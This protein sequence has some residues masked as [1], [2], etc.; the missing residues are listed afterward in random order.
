MSP[1]PQIRIPGP[2]GRSA[3]EA[4][5]QPAFCD[6]PDTDSV[7]YPYAAAPIPE[8]HAPGSTDLSPGCSSLVSNVVAAFSPLQRV[9]FVF[10]FKQNLEDMISEIVCAVGWLEEI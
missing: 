8:W 9:L 5:R 4:T 1:P 10:I 7:A 2:P 6:I 3:N